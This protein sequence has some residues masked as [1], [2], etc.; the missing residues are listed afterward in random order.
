M[1]SRLNDLLAVSGG[2]FGGGVAGIDDQP[3][4]LGDV[5]HV[6]GLVGG[7]DQDAVVGLEHRR[8]QVFADHFEIVLAQL[9]RLGD[10]RVVV[11]HLGAALA[12]QLDKLDGRRTSATLAEV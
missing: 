9:V 6:V 1:L 10:V 11:V 3:G 7:C 4:V 5:A 12:K 2:D 8:R